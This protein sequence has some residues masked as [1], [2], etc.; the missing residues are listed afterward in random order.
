MIE[1]AITHKCVASFMFYKYAY[2]N[3]PRLERWPE[4]DV[5]YIKKAF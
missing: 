3:K 1:E 4:I 2:Y 5:L